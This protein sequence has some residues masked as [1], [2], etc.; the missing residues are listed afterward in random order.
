MRIKNIS[1]GFIIALL[2]I[3]FPLGGNAQSAASGAKQ[4]AATVARSLP[5]NIE[6]GPAFEGITEYKF[7]NGL[8]VLLFPDQ[9]KSTVTVNIT[10]LVGSRHESYGHTGLAHLLEHMLFKGSP[11]H[12]NI[13]KE[14][15][16]RGAVF[17]GSTFNDYTNYYETVPATEENLRWALDLE[18][19][20][21]LNASLTQEDVQREMTVVHSEFRL[22]ENDPATVLRERVL[23]TAYLWHNYGRAPIGALS[24]L[25]QAPLEPLQDF[26]KLYYQPNNAVLLISGKFNEGTALEMV[27]QYFGQL[28][29]PARALPRAFTNEPV[30]DG[31]REINLRRNGS[32][33]IITCA[34]HIADGSHPDSA[35]LKVLTQI[36]V[37]APS[38]RLH[39]ALVESGKASA[40]NGSALQLY[41]PGVLLISA[42]VPE[43]KSLE[44]AR[45]VLLQELDAFASA[46]PAL[47]EVEAARQSLLASTQLALSDSA[48]AGI[49]LSQW[50]A[51]GDW[52][53][54]FLDRDRLSKVTPA[55]VQRVAA[56]YLKASNRTIGLYHPTAQPNHTEIPQKTDVTS[57]L[58]EYK[59]GASASAAVSSV[60]DFDPSVTNIESRVV[61][62]SLPAGL[63]LALLSKKN[64]GESVNATLR[65]HFGT[66]RTLAGRNVVGILTASLLN[67]GTLNHTRQQ[68]KEELDKLRARVSIAGDASL[69][70]VT[71]A[72][73]R[74]NLPA[75]LKLVSEALRSPAF[76]ESELE[77]LKQEHL[78]SIAASRTD[79]DTIAFVAL[80]RHLNRYPRGHLRYVSTPEER[81][82]DV[83]A[84]T[85]DE[86]KK[87]YG[88]FYGAG[89]GELSVVGD[90]DAAA[91]AALANEMFGD[92]KS[93]VPFVRVQEAVSKV[94]PVE[95]SFELPDKTNASLFAGA[96]FK[97]RDDDSDY[98]ALLLANY[99]FGGSGSLKS[100]LGDRLRQKE[101]LSYTVGS[102]LEV[103]Q[104]DRRARLLI[105]AV[106]APQH[107]PLLETALKEELER[108]LRDGFSDEELEAAKVSWLQAR[109]VSRAQ[110]K[111]LA[112]KL[113]L[114]LLLDRNLLWDQQLE[115]K[116]RALTSESVNAAWRRHLASSP[117]SIFK[118]GTFNK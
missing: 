57:L 115:T 105:Y 49:E 55:D 71:I 91:V 92:W 47:T 72:T 54:F 48:R 31:E 41:D 74:A 36:L 44:A 6:R 35:A 9:S 116:V 2:T 82:A 79:P 68:F 56:T 96:T 7:G 61:R 65:L 38:G 37:D 39:K 32:V 40:I 117:L 8:Q 26:Y 78:A 80:N 30:Q 58:G 3:A 100:R 114:Y 34:Y 11:R 51:K 94:P 85:L 17:N 12:Q 90:F 93:R 75:V 89:D 50:I 20:R 118:A 109:A 110:D 64:R 73:T 88:E 23:A 59:S 87:F 21:M 107:I 52:R 84:V 16:E 42:T 22:R 69:C 24:D 45:Q 66:P 27:G 14:L 1:C 112:N 28:P 106:G 95:Q 60:E 15:T 77:Q 5:L 86:V 83:Q 103:S 97:F 10:Y 25:E 70:N 113:A 111:D 98:P 63:K 43:G 81:A 4:P 18:A 62:S 13:S 104:Y 19:D 33:Q 76:L 67:R 53:L 101:G 99:M 29:R 46:P 108:S 102:D